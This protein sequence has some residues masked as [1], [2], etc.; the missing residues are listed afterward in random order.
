MPDGGIHRMYH[1]SCTTTTCNVQWLLYISLDFFTRVN[2]LMPTSFYLCCDMY[3][4]ECVMIILIS[5]F[6]AVTSDL[7]S[8]IS[9]CSPI[10]NPQSTNAHHWR[11][12]LAFGVIVDAGLRSVLL[13]SRRTPIPLL[14]SRLCF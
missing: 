5:L 6:S 11:L 12:A 1:H 3:I 13:C 2:E 7:L 10:P 8:N 14:L 9:L 4:K